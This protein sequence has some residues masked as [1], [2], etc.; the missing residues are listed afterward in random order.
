MQKEI[1]CIVLINLHIHLVNL[2]M[3]FVW[4]KN[5]IYVLQVPTHLDITAGSKNACV[6]ASIGE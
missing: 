2:A 5:T 6:R 3:P 1:I 4:I